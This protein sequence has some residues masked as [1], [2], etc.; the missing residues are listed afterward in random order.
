MVANHSFDDGRLLRAL[1]E[2]LKLPLIQIA[3]L[4]ELGVGDKES[5]EQILHTSDMAIQLIDGLLLSND[6]HAQQTLGLEPVSVSSVLLAAT[7]DLRHHAKNYGCEVELDVGGRFAPVM[8]N[9]RALRTAFTTLGYSMIEAQ[10]QELN[11]KIV[12]SVH[13]GNKGIVAGVFGGSN[14][15]TKDAFKRAK[16]LMGSAKQ[17]FVSKS[18]S[19]AAGIFI[20]DS[21]F[22]VI[23]SQLQVAKH[24]KLSGLTTTLT[25]SQQLKL[26]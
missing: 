15:I 9:F 4:A 25:P 3:R 23:A 8:G 18:S 20:A 10:T 13:L 16:A 26:V 21:L 19:S 1:A 11:N 22:S 7:E 17:P 14:E 2:Q 6:I 12:L 5:I 24:N